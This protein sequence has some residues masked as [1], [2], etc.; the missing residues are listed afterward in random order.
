[1]SLPEEEVAESVA[2]MAFVGSGR[3][4]GVVAADSMVST[5]SVEGSGVV[6][7][8]VLCSQLVVAVAMDM[9]SMISVEVRTAFIRMLLCR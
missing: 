4:T 9:A 2:V 7:L 1:M 3:L 6:V 8:V 5:G